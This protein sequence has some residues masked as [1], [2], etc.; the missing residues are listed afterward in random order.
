MYSPIPWFGGKGRMV[1]KILPYFPT[2][3]TTYA[4]PFSGAA[5][6]LFAKDPSPVEIIN[7]LD[8][9][10]INFFRV[11][12]DP[13]T[14]E[15]FERMVTMTPYS[16]EQYKECKKLAKERDPVERAWSFF[17]LARQSFSSRVHRGSFGTVITESARMMAAM[18]SKWLSA[19][20][21][22]PQV[23]NRLI[24]VQIENQDFR[25]FIKHYDRKTTFFYLDPPYPEVTRSGGG[26]KYELSD[27]DHKEMVELLLT[28]KGVAILSGYPTS[29]YDPL[30]E[31]GWQRVE[32]DHVC[33][34]A[35]KTKGSNLQGG[36]KIKEEQGRTECL[37]LSPKIPVT[38]D[39]V[40]LEQLFG[41]QG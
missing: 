30:V 33:Y 11:L 9:D 37:W 23:H 21:G 6:L 19:V 8:G 32:F 12:R 20:E 1:E 29:L 25:H 22:L 40:T 38:L 3:Y 17:V 36:G 15:Q 7:D 13:K 41:A 39:E 5:S 18:N 14:Y 34:A 26:F 24:E 16:R 2:G 31:T 35:G 10:L 28:I 27:E 4:E